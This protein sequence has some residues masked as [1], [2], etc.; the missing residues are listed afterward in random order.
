MSRDANTAI[1]P[2]VHEHVVRQPLQRHESY[3]FSAASVSRPSH[4][5]HSAFFIGASLQIG[6]ADVVRCCGRARRRQTRD[7]FRNNVSLFCCT[8]GRSRL[9]TDSHI[10]Q[11]RTWKSHVS[12]ITGFN[13]PHGVLYIAIHLHLQSTAHR[14][15]GNW[16]CTTL[17]R[18]DTLS[19]RLITQTT[20]GD[21]RRMA[22]TWRRTDM[23][24]V[25]LIA[26]NHWFVKTS[27]SVFGFWLDTGILGLATVLV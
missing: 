7:L 4:A 23:F 24:S 1:G 6:R 9:R 2:T 5:I 26:V 21:R 11:Q 10:S 3:N 16:V 27:W 8:A 18:F 15:T 25:E 20:C 22:E 17:P 19:L 14:P 13:A 12:E